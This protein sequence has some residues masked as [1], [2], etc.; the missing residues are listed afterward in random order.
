MGTKEN[1]TDIAFYKLMEDV[2]TQRFRIRTLI[3]KRILKHMLS[4]IKEECTI[5]FLIDV[6][7]ENR[8]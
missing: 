3:L 6:I 1:T 5:Y 7:K 2:Y 8:Q 4:K